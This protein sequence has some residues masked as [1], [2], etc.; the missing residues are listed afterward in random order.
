MIGR[1]LQEI[2]NEKGTNVNE[3]AKKID[4][5]PQTLYSIIKRD[6]MKADIDV[7]IKTCIVLDVNMERF[8][9]SYKDEY[10]ATRTQS[11]PDEILRTYYSLDMEDRLEVRGIIKYKLTDK[12]YKKKENL[13]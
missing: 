5:S 1:T 2:L 8:Y 4:V 10:L 6:N 7:L 12:K 3:L 9:G 13:A 11:D